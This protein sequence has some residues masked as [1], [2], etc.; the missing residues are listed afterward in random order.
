[1]IEPPFQTLLVPAIGASP[2]PQPGLMAAGETAI[3][4]SPITVGTQEEQSATFAE[5]AKTL[6]QNHF[7]IGRH[8]YLLAGL[9]SDGGFVAR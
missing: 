5:K 2:L 1:M 6:P 3:T 7:A 8:A 4:L 9:D